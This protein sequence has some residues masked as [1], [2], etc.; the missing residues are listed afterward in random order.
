MKYNLFNIHSM[1]LSQ[2]I[3]NAV[4][5]NEF[6]SQKFI[7]DE[8]VIASETKKRFPNLYNKNNK[9]NSTALNSFLI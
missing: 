7:V 9:L 8:V 4:F 2:L 5:E 6:D 3:N 1:A